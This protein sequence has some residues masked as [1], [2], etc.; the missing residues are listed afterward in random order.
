MLN[1]RIISL[2]VFAVKVYNFA[3]PV[4]VKE[5]LLIDE[6]FV[7]VDA[8]PAGIMVPNHSVL[9]CDSTIKFPY[10]VLSDIQLSESELFRSPNDFCSQSF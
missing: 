4:M 9:Q 3:L 5:I 8:G 1:I 10:Y 6:A 2:S 7:A